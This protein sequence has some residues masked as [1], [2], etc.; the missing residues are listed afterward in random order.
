MVTECFL[1]VCQV[2]GKIPAAENNLLTGEQDRSSFV[3][4]LHI[5]HRSREGSVLQD[6]EHSLPG[7]SK[8]SGL[9]DFGEPKQDPLPWGDT[10]ILWQIKGSSLDFSGL[11]VLGP[12]L[13]IA[14]P[15]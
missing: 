15:H 11:V 10:E 1:K 3:W 8:L 6:A 7:L 13:L 9:N 12:S 5:G 4:G 2:H 14:G